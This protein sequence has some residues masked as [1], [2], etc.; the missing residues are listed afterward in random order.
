MRAIYEDVRPV[1]VGSAGLPG[2]RYEGYFDVAGERVAIRILHTSQYGH[3]GGH[4]SVL[5]R[6]T[7][8]TTGFD[9]KVL[10]EVPAE[11]VDAVLPRHGNCQAPTADAG[12][13]SPVIEE[14]LRRGNAI[15]V[16]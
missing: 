15:L 10:S 5:T 6:P 7:T 3:S 4:I 14:L 13:F 2:V 8:M 16:Q 1:R 11:F 12:V 9:W